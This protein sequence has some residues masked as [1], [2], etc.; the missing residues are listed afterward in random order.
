MI[1]S[2]MVVPF[3]I[4]CVSH[5]FQNVSFCIFFSFFHHSFWPCRY[6]FSTFPCLWE[7]R[8]SGQMISGTVSWSLGLGSSSDHMITLAVRSRSQFCSIG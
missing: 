4:G 5:S 1:V 3:V 6:G 7:I 2:F 8:F